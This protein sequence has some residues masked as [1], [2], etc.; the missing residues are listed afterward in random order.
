MNWPFKFLS[1][2]W[3]SWPWSMLLTLCQLV[4]KHSKHRLQQPFMNE[5]KF[6]S[7]NRIFLSCTA[8]NRRA[9]PGKHGGK[10][11]ASAPASPQRNASEKERCGSGRVH[12]DASSP[13]LTLHSQWGQS[14]G[15]R[16]ISDLGWDCQAREGEEKPETHEVGFQRNDEGPP[17]T[18]LSRVYFHSFSVS[19]HWKPPGMHANRED[20]TGWR[21]LWKI[22][23]L[24]LAVWT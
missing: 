9:A 22:K 19:V 14:R 16:R 21:T 2:C 6:H 18:S 13:K 17:F 24:G 20:V 3:H 8:G 12:L 10:H 7:K 15:S 23:C 1:L 5:S 4:W 11:P